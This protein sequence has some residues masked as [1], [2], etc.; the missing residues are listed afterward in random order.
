LQACATTLTRL[1]ITPGAVQPTPAVRPSL[2]LYGTVRRGRCQLRDTVPPTFVWLTRRALEGGRRN[3]RRGNKYSFLCL[4]RT[5][6][7]VKPAEMIL[8]VAISPVRPSLPLQHHSRHGS[9]I[10]DTVKAHGDRTSPHPLLCLV[11][12]PVND[13]V[14][15]ARGRRPDE[16]PL[17]HHHRSCSGMG[18]GHA[19][20]PQQEEDSPGQLSILWHCTPCL[21]T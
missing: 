8:S 10:P 18:I 2:S 12:P 20:T 19:M 11:R 7:D 21:H 6:H 1:G 9:V 5:T 3:P 16:Q 14:E 17:R 4:H 13:T 15:S